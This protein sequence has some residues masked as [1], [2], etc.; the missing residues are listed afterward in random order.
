MK[1][2]SASAASQSVEELIA[3]LRFERPDISPNFSLPKP[4]GYNDLMKSLEELGLVA[5]VPTPTKSK[6]KNQVKSA[7]QL[8]KVHSEK[9]KVVNM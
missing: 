3:A 7:Q 2:P 4:L 8:A 1:V 9:V 5:P 6:D